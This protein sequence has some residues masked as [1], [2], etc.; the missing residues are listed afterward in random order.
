VTRSPASIHAT[1]FLL[2]YNEFMKSYLEKHHRLFGVVGGSIALVVAGIYLKVIPEEAS[3]VGRLQNI[4]LVYGHSLCWILLSAASILWAI[5]KKNKW[6]EF[7]AFAAL[8]TYFIF[9]S[10]LLSTKFT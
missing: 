1:G 10:T 8:F 6:S 4:I 5:M 7:L 9:M 2:I 3:T